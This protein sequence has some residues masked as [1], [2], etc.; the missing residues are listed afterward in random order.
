M[1]RVCRLT[2]KIYR[3]MLCITKHE[4]KTYIT[5]SFGPATAQATTS[6]TFSWESQYGIVLS[7]DL[8]VYISAE[9]KIPCS[10]TNFITN[11]ELSGPLYISP[12]IYHTQIT[13]FL[14]W[15]LFSLHRT[16]SLM[17]S[18]RHHYR[19]LNPDPSLWEHLSHALPTKKIFQHLRSI[20]LDRPIHDY[21][22]GLMLDTLEIIITWLHVSVSECNWQTPQ[23]KNP[24]SV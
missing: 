17:F 1:E 8:L 10:F 6:G 18:V 14:L 23:T 11:P 16:S 4:R 9:G 12:D 7:W 15:A 20:R 5:I 19:L 2:N 21:S 22:T 24:I 3:E 13:E